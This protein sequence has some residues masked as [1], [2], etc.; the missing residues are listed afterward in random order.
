MK[1]VVAI[2]VAVMGSLVLGAAVLGSAMS[3]ETGSVAAG[4]F[5]DSQQ[6]QP[7]FEVVNQLGGRI[8]DIEQYG[9]FMFMG[10]GHRLTVWDASD[11]LQPV[12]LSQTAILGDG[13]VGNIRIGGNYLY[14]I[15]GSKFLI[16]NVSVPA[17]PVEVGSY[18]AGGAIYQLA[19]FDDY[20]YLTNYGPEMQIID[21]TNP[22]EPQEVD[23]LI[24]NPNWDL[25]D[26]QLAEN[27]AIVIGYDDSDSPYHTGRLAILDLTNPI[28]PT[29]VKTQD[30]YAPPDLVVHN[31]YA[32]LTYYIGRHD[33]TYYLSAMEIG[34][35]GGAS[36]VLPHAGF[37]VAGAWD[38]LYMYEGWCEALCVL[39]ITDP[40]AITVVG[41]YAWY[42]SHFALIGGFL[43]LLDE[44]GFHILEPAGMSEVAFLPTYLQRAWSANIAGDYLLVERCLFN[45]VQ[46]AFPHPIA[47]LP[48]ITGF[49]TDIE[50]QGN[51]AYVT[52]LS[53]F[54]V[55]DLAEPTSPTIVGMT[56]PPRAG[57]DVDIVGDYAFVAGNDLDN[58]LTIIDISE[59]TIPT[60]ISLDATLAYGRDMVVEGN[61]VYFIGA[62]S[63][64][65][66]LDATNPESPIRVGHWAKYGLRGIAKRG[67]YVYV[68]GDYP[69]GVHVINIANPEAPFEAGFFATT[70]NATGII[71]NGQHA[72]AEL[73][74]GSIQVVDI[75]EPTNPTDAGLI[76]TPG[77]VI[78]VAVA[79]RY[80]HLA[81]DTNGLYILWQAIPAVTTLPP[82][83]G[84]LTSAEDQA[85]Y[86]FPAG[87]FSDTVTITHTARY[88]G[89]LPATGELAGIG[90]FF[91][92][93][94]VYSGTNGAAEPIQPYALTIHYTESERG[95]AIEETLALYYWDG[96]QWVQEA[97]SV[98]DP[99]NNLIIAAPDRF[100]IWAVLGETQ[101]T[102]F[103]YGPRK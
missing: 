93:R 72:L 102:F 96:S 56:N 74:S 13:P 8:S 91:E 18:M 86:A 10:V 35:W 58:G 70:S 57:L 80:L 53:G 64:L 31:G 2:L 23:T 88:P 42:G 69:D 61:Y 37:V 20:A 101:R 100:G 75:S 50:I 14:L 77:L 54:F 11:P 27:F 46:P 5:S 76:D 15:A 81:D 52:S 30:Y 98:V 19:I 33:Q 28:S 82:A 32:Y 60:V 90:H 21:I 97:S 41:D 79:G 26:I 83:G 92:V 24:I 51:Y 9:D 44:S 22:A 40:T 59:P 6:G 3:Q 67:E 65:I 34:N 66:I 78:K 45:I 99:A 7:Q 25:V 95:A 43:Y 103:P 62:Y 49:V 94:G 73:D 48:E 63:G 36:Y 38:R 89:N 39:D 84:S 55:V 16:F 85:L 1:G 4:P 47:C 71:L 12:Q 68:G 17:A 29:M 87:T